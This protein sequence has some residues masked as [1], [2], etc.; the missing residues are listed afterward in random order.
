MTVTV[1]HAQGF[2]DERGVREIH[3]SQQE[4]KNVADIARRTIERAAAS[5]DTE[6]VTFNRTWPLDGYGQEWA[7]VQV[8]AVTRTTLDGGETWTEMWHWF[9]TASSPWPLSDTPSDSSTGGAK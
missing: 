3:V 1:L 2:T 8:N 4:G 6:T 5:D 9:G 7:V